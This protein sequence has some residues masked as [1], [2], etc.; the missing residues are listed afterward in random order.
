M[1]NRI[2]L[3]APALKNRLQAEDTLRQIAELTI[4]RNQAQL[5]M[6]EQITAIRKQYEEALSDANKTLEEK[7]ELV[8]AWAEANPSEFNGLKSL[9]CVHAVIG[10]RTGQP[11]LKTLSGWTWDRVLE[12]LKSSRTWACYVRIKEEVDKAAILRD[13]DTCFEDLRNIG[14]KVVQ[15]EAFFVEPKLQK[16]ETKQAA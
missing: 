3:T 16:L 13:R 8:R 1:K 9:E 5:D 11:T 4:Q 2:K 10:W 15:S 7:T 6:D 14:V 12:K